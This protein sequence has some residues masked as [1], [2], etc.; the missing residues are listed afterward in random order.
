M[1]GV[2]NR[3][4]HWTRRMVG[5]DARSEPAAGGPP[6][7]PET[8][9]PALAPFE[10][11]MVR[12]RAVGLRAPTLFLSFDADTPLDPPAAL[13][14]MAFLGGLGIKA[15]LA[16]PGTELENAAATYRQLADG[17]VEFMNHGYLPHAEWREDQYV[18][19]TFYENMALED[20][21]A[22]I[23]RGDEVVTRITGRRPHGFRAPHFGHFR[24]PAQLAFKHRVASEL[25]YA[26]CST[27]LPEYGLEHGPVTEVAPGL[28]E[29][30]TFGS[31]ASPT[32]VL[33]S[34]TY[35]SNRKQY[36]LSDTYGDLVIETVD[37]LIARELP[38]LLAWYADPCH[39]AGQAPF[40][41]AM[42]HLADKWIASLAGIEAARLG[43]GL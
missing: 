37:A 32:S 19:I 3:L 15:T 8:G 11:Y 4:A 17:G 29:L 13:E 38:A 33:D 9:T 30:P 10:R 41:R 12:A 5:A 36:A 26:Y 20:V 14:V 35:L 39:V 2:A 25:G 27:T 21:E 43:R 34:W 6:P 42:R 1:M 16:V 40:E 31:A 24:E 7:A 22:D 28:V 18:G 23:R